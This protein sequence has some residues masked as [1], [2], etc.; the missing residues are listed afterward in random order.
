MPHRRRNKSKEDGTNGATVG[1]DKKQSTTST[2]TPGSA[3]N[4]S[5]SSQPRKNGARKTT[6]GNEV[7][8]DEKTERVDAEDTTREK[9]A[10]TEKETRPKQRPSSLSD[11]AVVDAS[12]EIEAPLTH[13]L[14]TLTTSSSTEIDAALPTVDAEVE[15]DPDNL[16]ATGE[17]RREFRFYLRRLKLPLSWLTD[18][19]HGCYLHVFPSLFFTQVVL[20]RSWKKSLRAK[21]A[22]GQLLP[23]IKTQ[24]ASLNPNPTSSAVSPTAPASSGNLCISPLITPTESKVGGMGYVEGC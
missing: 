2:V 11:S 7:G 19:Y 16:G 24:R 4:V 15:D 9:E 23:W 17:R 21:K 8:I 6:P 20:W 14:A 18:L 10:L 13:R 5:Q 22:I 1:P 12:A 3:K